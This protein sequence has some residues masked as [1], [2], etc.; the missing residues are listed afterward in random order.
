MRLKA[1]IELW[2]KG[3][4]YMAK[5]P[6][7]DFIAQGRTM[8]EAKANLIEVIRIQFHEMKEMGTLDEYLAECGFIVKD[9]TA[10]AENEMVGF[11]KQMLQVS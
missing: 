6:E 11:E 1:T 9:D 5:I 8:E 2:Q 10:E 4:W 3:K 7:L